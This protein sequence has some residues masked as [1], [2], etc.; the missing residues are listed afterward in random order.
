[1][2]YA[3]PIQRQELITGLRA[4]AGFL[5]QNP[6]V[7]APPSA[8]VLVFPPFA[9]HAENKHEVDVI[10]SRIGSGTETSY[11]DRH[12]TTSRTFGRVG[13]H[14]VAIPPDRSREQ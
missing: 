11:P 4:L 8:D 2:T 14:A 6:G 1:M 7:P 12:Y 10:A 9:T 13:Y 3:N 5:E